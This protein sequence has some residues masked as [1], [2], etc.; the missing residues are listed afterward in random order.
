[1]KFQGHIL[2]QA[3]TLQLAGNSFE[4]PDPH[5]PETYREILSFLGCMVLAGSAD[6]MVDGTIGERDA[7]KLRAALER[8]QLTNRIR[9]IKP[10]GGKV[11]IPSRQAIDIVRLAGSWDSLVS[12]ETAP[13]LRLAKEQAAEA[14]QWLSQA[15]EM[16]FAL[17][18]V[19]GK[20]EEAEA[21]AEHFASAEFNRVRGNKLFSALAMLESFGS[22]GSQQ[23]SRFVTSYLICGLRWTI[24]HAFRAHHRVSPLLADGFRWF[25]RRCFRVFRKLCHG[26]P[27]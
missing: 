6:L 19:A 3:R 14:S 24:F 26:R 8:L 17:K 22:E 12:G 23:L 21:L 25:G 9:W 13:D 27:L 15:D 5:G 2:I 4:S 10:A 11:T 7:D 18:N 1:M 16:V 20:P